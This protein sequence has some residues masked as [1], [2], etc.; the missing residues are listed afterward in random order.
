[1]R[2][3]PILPGLV[4]ALTCLA[5]S[6]KLPEVVVRDISLDTPL[7]LD[8]N[9]HYRLEHVSV[10]G[11]TDCAAITL[12]GRI[13][14]VE[15]QNCN[16]GRVWTGSEGKAAGLDAAGAMVGRVRAIDCSFFDAENQ[17]LS[18]KEGS[19]GSVTFER[20]RF[21]TSDSFMRQVQEANP[22]R[23][24]PPTTEFYNIQR[25]EL[26]DNDFVNTTVIIHPSVKQVV[27]RGGL[28]GIQIVN[29]QATKVIQL[30]NGG[31][32]IAV[33]G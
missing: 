1:M 10:V 33:A 25:L 17:L 31:Q 20:C 4:V 6:P 23:D 32:P 11:V 27:I 15:M 16:F 19:F 28:P 8:D 2:L 9:V 3:I 24:F 18:L 14:S 13:G 29:P 26:F 30:E 21:T 12:A 7:V 22:W 5:A